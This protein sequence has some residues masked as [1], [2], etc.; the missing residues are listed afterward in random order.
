MFTGIYRTSERVQTFGCHLQGPVV[1]SCSLL[2]RGAALL[3]NGV[4]G[5]FAVSM[6]KSESLGEEGKT[7]YNGNGAT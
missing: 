6:L 4:S 5:L 7:I 3:V 1:D 2:L